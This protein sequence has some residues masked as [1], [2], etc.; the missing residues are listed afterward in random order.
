MPVISQTSHVRK[1]LKS[2]QL[3]QKRYY[4]RGTRILPDLKKKDKNL[5]LNR[6]RTFLVPIPSCSTENERDGA[7]GVDIRD[8]IVVIDNDDEQI[9]EKGYKTA[10]GRIVRKRDSIILLQTNHDNGM[11]TILSDEIVFPAP[12]TADA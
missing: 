8:D 9:D 10:S 1:Q 3:T 7:D 6:N 12:L 11:F 5:V 2:K 4:D